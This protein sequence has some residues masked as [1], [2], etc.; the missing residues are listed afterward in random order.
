M[1]T[2]D[3]PKSMD[4]VVEGKPLPNSTYSLRLKEPASLEPNK[5]MREDPSSEKAGFNIVLKL[6]TFGEPDPL[7][8][9]REFIVWLSMPKPS[10]ALRTTKRGQTIT[11]WKMQ[12]IANAVRALGGTISGPSVE[13]P[14]GA[15][16]K[17]LIVQTLDQER[18]QI[19]NDI[20]GDLKPFE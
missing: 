11:D 8:N 9:G 10:D 18:Q 12:N 17:A 19:L 6:E 3:L 4:D 7:L 14:E 5:A 15:L 16:C 2:F 13:I 20:S 1:A